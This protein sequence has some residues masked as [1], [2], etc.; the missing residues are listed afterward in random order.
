MCVHVDVGVVGRGDTGKKGMEEIRE[1][2]QV[3]RKW[4]RLERG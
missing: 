3:K 2:I 4:R 1:G